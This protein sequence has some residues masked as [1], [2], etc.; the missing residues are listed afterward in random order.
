MGV[1]DLDTSSC[2]VARVALDAR[3]S[4]SQAHKSVTTYFLGKKDSTSSALQAL[5]DNAKST[6]LFDV[7]L[8]IS[9]KISGLDIYNALESDV[10]CLL[11]PPSPIKIRGRHFVT[12]TGT[13]CLS[14]PRRPH[15][16]DLRHLSL[17]YLHR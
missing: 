13:H 5:L 7:V 4:L 3:C 8:L 6:G 17:Q 10:S 1:S 11:E 16:D 2:E 12:C 9:T 14:S 15:V